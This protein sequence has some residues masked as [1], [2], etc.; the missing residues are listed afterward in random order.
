[1][2]YVESL[3]KPPA[4]AAKHHIHVC[5][6]L[7]AM[8]LLVVAVTYTRCQHGRLYVMQMMDWEELVQ[9]FRYQWP[10]AQVG[11]A[12]TLRRVYESYV[13]EA[14]SLVAWAAAN[15]SEQRLLNEREAQ[16]VAEDTAADLGGVSQQKVLY[17]MYAAYI[18][19]CFVC[20]SNELLPMHV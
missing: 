1:M 13:Q 3:H 4:L 14:G 8:Q 10:R 18:H 19:V 20:H 16:A 7:K 6:Q 15:P 2:Q 5:R 17:C 11:Q 9:G 12:Q